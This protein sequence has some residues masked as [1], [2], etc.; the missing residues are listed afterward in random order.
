MDFRLITGRLLFP[1]AIG[2]TYAGLG[3]DVG[4]HIK[5]IVAF[6]NA[7]QQSTDPPE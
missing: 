3:T 5:T 1:R 4:G 7:R 2:N 6:A